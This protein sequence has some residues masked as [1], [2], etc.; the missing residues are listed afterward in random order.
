M[1]HGTHPR[2]KNNVLSNPIFTRSFSRKLI[3]AFNFFD[4]DYHF[5][6]GYSFPPKSVCLILTEKCNLKCA[7][8]DIGQ[9]NAE[10]AQGKT[11]PLVK[12]ISNGDEEMSIDNWR[13]L[14]HDLSRLFPKPRILLTGTEPFMYPEIL[15]IIE[16]IVEKKLSLHITTNGTLL[17]RYARK[18][19]ELCQSPSGV[20]MAVS[21]DDIGEAHDRI[22][23]V[24]GTFDRAIEGIR[25]VVNARE[26]KKQLFPLIN[27]TCAISSYNYERLEAFADWFTEQKI[28]AESI[29]FNHLWFR[30]AAIAESHNRRYGKE[31]PAEEENMDGVDI[32]S[33]DMV[34]V[35]RQLQNIKKKCTSTPLRIYQ[36]PDLSFD[37]AQQYY[38]YPTH[39]VFYDTCKAPWRNVSVTPKGNIILSPLCFLPS[40]GNVKKESFSAIWSGEQ[41]KKL[42][43]DLKKIKAYPACSRC[44]LLFDSKTKYYKIASMLR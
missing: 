43:A 16:M 38:K 32:S 27:I 1:Q 14:I 40:L 31:L 33:I 13:T 9:Q 20:D 35:A 18:F 24:P 12:S 34:Q 10:P 11:S 37:A 8:C 3:H 17:T 22:R 23:G 44:C 39:F 41:F 25:A 29:T 42:R 6:A 7:M 36:H 30:D 19:V 15:K 21:V 5:L 28:P 2:H 26:E 4:I